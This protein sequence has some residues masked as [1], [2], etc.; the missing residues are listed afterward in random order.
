MQNEVT[1]SLGTDDNRMRIK[2]RAKQIAYVSDCPDGLYVK[3]AVDDF[4]VIQ[5]R[6]IKYVQTSEVPTM[7]QEAFKQFESLPNAP[8]YPFAVI[9]EEQHDD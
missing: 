5:N 1:T 3:I 9:A 6:S 7:Y 4:G 8:K 2:F